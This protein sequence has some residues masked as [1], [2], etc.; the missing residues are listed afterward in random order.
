VARF[1]TL[2]AINHILVLFIVV[3]TI[4]NLLHARVHTEISKL[5]VAWGVGSKKYHKCFILG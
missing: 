5:I 1:S 4:F 3:V 2:F